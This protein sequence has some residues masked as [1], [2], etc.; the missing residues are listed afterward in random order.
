MR[1]NDFGRSLVFAA[2]AAAAA[3]PYWLAIAPALGWNTALSSYAVLSTSAYLAGVGRSLRQGLGAA[4]LAFALGSAAAVLA[5][6]PREALAAAA[7]LLGLCRSGLLYRARFGRAV[8]AESVLLV[9]ALGLANHLLAGSPF[10][11]VLAV[12]G[13]FLV[14]SAFFLIGATD[15]RV[16]R[17]VGADPFEV[18]VARVGEIL[19]REGAGRS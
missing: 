7:V 3:V 10:S 4:L 18:A 11:A 9:A 6:S 14:Q 1:W 12:W 17:P 8:V 5:P 2:V 19:E 13:F 15:A 16:E